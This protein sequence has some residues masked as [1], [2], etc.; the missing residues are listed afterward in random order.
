MAP[1]GRR[2]TPWLAEMDGAKS[3]AITDPFCGRQVWIW[4]GP[5][6]IRDAKPVPG[7]MAE[8]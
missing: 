6:R 2:G 4:D 8:L 1:A 3:F 5:S 7:S